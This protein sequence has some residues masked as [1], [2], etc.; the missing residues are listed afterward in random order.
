MILGI[1]PATKYSGI[2][3]ID[4]SVF[5]AKMEYT[6]FLTSKWVGKNKHFKYFKFIEK[7]IGVLPKKTRVYIEKPIPYY[8]EGKVR[9]L[10]GYE[11]HIEILT[12][13]LLMLDFKG[14]GYTIVT[15]SE[16]QKTVGVKR[17]GT[18]LTSKEQVKNAVFRY[19][20]LSSEKCRGWKFDQYDALGIALFGY[21][22]KDDVRKKLYSLWS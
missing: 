11:S 14:I 21:F 9:N 17:R 5:P 13:W 10:K 6:K 18:G 20:G 7:E 4:D 8:K 3:L 12:L 22:Q 16:W 1:D 19:F 2:A 15:P